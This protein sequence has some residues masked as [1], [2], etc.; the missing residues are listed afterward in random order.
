MLDGK[1]KLAL[2]ITRMDWAGSAD[3][4]RIL[5]SNLSLRQYQITCIIGKTNYPTEK[6]KRFLE[7]YKNKIIFLPQLVR[8]IRPLYDIIALIRLWCI[9]RKN[10]FDIVHT[11]TAKAGV[12]GRLAAFLAGVRIIVHTPHGHN[13]YGYYNRFICWLIILVEKIF[14]FFTTKL[15]V[16][17]ELEKHDYLRWAI[18]PKEKIV[19]VPTVVEINKQNSDESARQ[20]ARDFLGLTSN[21]LVVG[22]VGRFE[23]IKGLTY[24]LEA[25]KRILTER[26]DVVFILIGDGS[27]REN[28]RQEVRRIKL[29]NN[30]RF[31]GWRE[32]AQELMAAFDVLVLPSLNEAVGLVLLE[33]QAQAVPV[34]ATKVGGIPEVVKDRQSGILVSPKDSRALS[35]AIEELLDSEQKRRRYGEYGKVFIKNK[36]GKENFIM[37]ME[38][39]YSDVYFAK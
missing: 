25:A 15:V 13:F 22:F 3:I 28:L 38:K 8:D 14:A 23:P 36:F 11:H 29:E 24:L 26:K 16:L 39:V 18:F 34:I 35:E 2:V 37:N 32:D 27:L 1:I 31:F 33:A 17:T 5:A 30:I 19:V 6:T 12:L 7:S 20:K 21:Q 9:F 4:F 10:R